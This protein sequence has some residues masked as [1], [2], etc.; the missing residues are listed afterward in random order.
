VAGNAKDAK[1]AKVFL[2]GVGAS[3]RPWAPDSGLL[4]NL[5]IPRIFARS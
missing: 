3:D 2:S 5:V 1:V 4:K